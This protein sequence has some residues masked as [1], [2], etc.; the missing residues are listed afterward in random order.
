MSH[1]TPDWGLTTGVVTTYKWADLDELAVRLGS[2]VSFDRRGDVLFWDGFED[3]YGKWNL[4]AVGTNAAIDLSLASAHNGACSLRMVPG[5]SGLRRA[6]AQRVLGYPVLSAFGL[7]A[8]FTLHANLQ[9][10]ALNIYVYTGA[11]VWQTL[12]RYDHTTGEAQIYVPP[13]DW[14]TIHTLTNPIVD[15]RGYHTWKL[16][17]D[18]ATGLYVRSIL[19]DEEVDISAYGL[20]SPVSA[21]SPQLLAEAGAYSIAANTATVYLDDVIL[22]QNEPT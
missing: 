1:G 11:L 9:Y 16:V 22:T 2:P 3:G 4:S 14:Q 21:T 13:A 12:G 10:F 8:S 7:E 5:S 19:D 15:S 17:G 6:L 20:T 18:P